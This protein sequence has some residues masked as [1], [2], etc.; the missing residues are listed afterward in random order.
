[1]SDTA[2]IV[3]QNLGRVRQ[4]IADAAADSG[5]TANEIQLV[6]VTKYV[7]SDVARALSDAGCLALGESRPQQLVEKA[8]ALADTSIQWH[9]IG[10]LQRNKVRRV[11]PITSLIHSGDSLRLL[12]AIDRIATEDDLPGIRVLLEVNVSGEEAKHGFAPEDVKP[13][14]APLAQLT[15]VEIAGLMCM[16]RRASQ[17]EGARRDF[18]KLRE[19]RDQLRAD[20]PDSISLDALSMG[21]SGDYADAIREGATI[22]RVGSALFE[23]VR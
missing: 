16:A 5:R 8:N 15:H 3:Q 1:M 9:M 6:G 20:C 23:G 13:A 22:V 12:E 7:E 2:A 11:L 4:T 18:A 17:G 21:M 19:L 14:L 10:H